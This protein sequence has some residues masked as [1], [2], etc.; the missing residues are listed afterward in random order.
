[1][2]AVWNLYQSLVSARD[3]LFQPHRFITAHRPGLEGV[4]GEEGVE[5]PYFAKVDSRSPLLSNNWRVPPLVGRRSALDLGARRQ[6][7]AGPSR[8]RLKIRRVI[9]P[10]RVLP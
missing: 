4:Q 1:M 6:T 7:A 10:V 2:K 3:L 8:F 5:E 9:C